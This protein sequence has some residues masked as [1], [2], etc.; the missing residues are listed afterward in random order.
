M[1]I[2]Y[3]TYSIDDAL[4]KSFKYA[5]LSNRKALTKII[6]HILE[7]SQTNHH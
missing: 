1:N 4:D 2:P 6:D 5:N 7:L 3:C